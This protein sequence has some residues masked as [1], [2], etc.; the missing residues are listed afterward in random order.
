[1]HP[2]HRSIGELAYL[3]WQARGCPQGTAHEDWLEAERQL[4]E[5]RAGART[6]KADAAAQPL[7]VEESLVV[8]ESRIVDDAAPAKADE[9]WKAAGTARKRP[10]R[11][12]SQAKSDKSKPNNDT[13]R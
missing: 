5:E 10:A 7:I 3:L 8:S 13:M 4:R 9:K 6:P 2:E 1:M 12:R 11:A